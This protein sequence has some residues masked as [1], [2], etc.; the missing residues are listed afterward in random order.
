[1]KAWPFKLRSIRCSPPSYL[2][3]FNFPTSLLFSIITPSLNQGPWLEENL[4]SVRAAG[5]EVE[6]I[7]IDGG[8][9]DETVPLLRAQSFASWISEPDRG[10]TDAINKGLRR[11]SGEILGYLCADDYY[12][13]GALARV[14]EVF[15]ADPAI[16]VVFGD[17]W[18]LE[19]ASGW[20]RRK[21]V[22]E[23]SSARLR[24]GNFLIQPAVFWRRTVLEHFG[25]FDPELQF[26][27]DHEYWL[28]IGAYTRW[29]Y[30]AEPLATCRL[31]GGAKT[32]RAL[33]PA[34]EEAVAM[35]ARYGMVVRPRLEALWMRLGGQKYYGLKRALF[36]QIG[37]WEGRKVQKWEGGNEGR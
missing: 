14:A 24:R 2:P 19:G 5:S 11:S 30:L 9:T 6:H 8:S 29:Q 31:H 33:I 27:M 34:W 21:S 26:C 25:E 13:P 36:A 12:E 16:Q 37:R 32:S 1:M 28:R 17:G 22:G 35:Q 7:V 18:F 3:T 4:A 20:K 23:F 15:S 10:Q